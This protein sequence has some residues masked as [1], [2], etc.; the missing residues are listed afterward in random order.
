MTFHGPLRSSKVWSGWPDSNRRPPDHQSGALS[1][2]RYIPMCRA[3]W[4][5]RRELR[6]L[7]DPVDDVRGDP[8]RDAVDFPLVV[9][10]RLAE[11]VRVRELDSIAGAA[12]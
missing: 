1:R 11:T 8:L 5:Y 12:S 6:R 7:D 3:M 10:T 4:N 9:L 2:L